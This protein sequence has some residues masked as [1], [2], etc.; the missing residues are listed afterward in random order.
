MLFTCVS[1]KLYDGEK[2]LRDINTEWAKQL[3]SLFHEGV[4]AGVPK[5]MICAHGSHKSKTLVAHLSHTPLR[6]VARRSGWSGSPAK[7][8]GL[9]WERS[10]GSVVQVERFLDIISIKVSTH[11]GSLLFSFMA[12]WGFQF[13]N[14]LYLKEG[15]PPLHWWGP[16]PIPNPKCF[17]SLFDPYPIANHLYNI[18]NCI[19]IL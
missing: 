1:S 19:Y 9:T 4:Q 8:T 10:L 14:R 3:H 12:N 11:L 16:G 15:V 17:Q 5:Y 2:T 6:W 7:A 13:G 18:N